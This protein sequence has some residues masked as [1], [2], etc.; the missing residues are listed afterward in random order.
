MHT[1]ERMLLLFFFDSFFHQLS[2]LLLNLGIHLFFFFLLLLLASDISP[3]SSSLEF[4]LS[5]DA[6]LW[7]KVGSLEANGLP[8]L[9]TPPVLMTDGMVATCSDFS[10]VD[11]VLTLG[12]QNPL[13][14]KP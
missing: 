2:R 14:V 7:M 4:E 1:E 5:F 8:E 9:E 10:G 12:H 3:S 13:A 11:T 6:T